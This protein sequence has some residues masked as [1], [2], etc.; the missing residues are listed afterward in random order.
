MSGKKNPSCSAVQCAPE[1]SMMPCSPAATHLAGSR[2]LAAS[3][4]QA[5]EIDACT[6]T[7]AAARQPSITRSRRAY[8]GAEMML[9]G[10]E[11]AAAWASSTSYTLPSAASC[12]A[13]SRSST[14]SAFA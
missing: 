14:Y 11:A 13:V 12:S 4:R 5:R 8:A 10:A 2:F 9:P 1:L 6:P 7:P 3:A